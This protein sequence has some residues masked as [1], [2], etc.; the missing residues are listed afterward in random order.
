[1]GVVLTD[2]RPVHLTAPVGQAKLREIAIRFAEFVARAEAARAGDDLT[3]GACRTIR[4]AWE[5]YG[6]SPKHIESR[7]VSMLPDAEAAKDPG[8]IDFAAIPFARTFLDRKGGADIDQRLSIFREHAR[9]ALEKMYPDADAPPDEV[10]HVSTTGYL[11][12]SPVHELVS[13]NGWHRTTVSHCYHQGC[14]GAFP[15][16]RMAAGSL[17][18]ARGGLTRK[19]GRVDI[20]HTEIC[21]IH[22]A[23]ECV[24]AEHIICDSLFG[25]GFIRYSA[26]HADAFRERGGAGLE[27]VCCADTTIPASLDA[28]SW[29][30]MANRFEMTLSVDV[31]RL[32]AAH[33]GEFIG[34]LLQETGL[35]LP[36]EKGRII[37]VI[38]PGGPAIVEF[39]G[40][41]LGLSKDQIG[42]GKDA[43]REG[44]NTSS[45]TVARIW[46]RILE[47]DSV[48]KG[49]PVVSMAFGPGLT[50]TAMVARVV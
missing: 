48:P 21:S 9:A 7:R 29:R 11:L 33:I 18:A 43:L 10:I 39:V 19:R 28:M 27:V 1:M 42:G 3:E 44:G 22:V 17:A 15:A 46:H 34:S 31:P 38:H 24:D 23:P 40:H 20:A 13:R 32:I 16:V 6:V 14:Y 2:F 8:D 26:C 4:E 35:D 30:P 12:P 25:D 37:W 49:T 50:A 47:D 5:R 45:A 41:C 36:S